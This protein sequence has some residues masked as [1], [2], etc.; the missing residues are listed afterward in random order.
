LLEIYEN[1]N[2]GDTMPQN[3]KTKVIRIERDVKDVY[4]I[5]VDDI[6]MFNGNGIINHNSNLKQVECWTRKLPIV[7]SDVPPYNVH[8][9]HMENCIL[10]PV[11]NN[12]QKYWQKYLKM[13]ILDPDLRKNLVNSY[14]KILKKNTIL[15]MLPRKELN[16]IKK[17]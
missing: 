10:V 4:D 8:G 11:E 13:L 17:L 16:S 12:A 7:C 9:R 3:F 15:Q 6:H 1:K 14:M 5:E 2:L